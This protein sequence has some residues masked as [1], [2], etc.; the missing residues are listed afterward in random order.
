V[1]C[2]PFS[3]VHM[4]AHV[5]FS[6]HPFLGKWQQVAVV[7]T[8]GW[9]LWFRAGPFLWIALAVVGVTAAPVGWA[10]VPVH[11][12]ALLPPPLVGMRLGNACD[13]VGSPCWS[14]TPLG[15]P[16]WPAAPPSVCIYFPYYLFL[17]KCWQFWTPA[18]IF[19]WIA[20]AAVGA[21]PR[22]VRFGYTCGTDACVSPHPCWVRPPGHD[23]MRCLCLHLHPAANLKLV[24]TKGHDKLGVGVTEERH[25]VPW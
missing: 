21:V 24:W 1:A 13:A 9:W 15:P 2:C 18:G 7:V 12:C 10:S 6:S 25:E 4:P 23:F 11:T 19:P 20:L 16:L 14:S 3:C 17:G 5:Y 8:Y 22:G